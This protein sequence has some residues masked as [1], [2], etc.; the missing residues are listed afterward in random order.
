MTDVIL[1]QT[2]KER[3]LP[4]AKREQGTIVDGADIAS[5]F[6]SIKKQYPYSYV[7]IIRSGSGRL[8]RSVALSDNDAIRDACR[9]L[10]KRGAIRVDRTTLYYGEP[11]FVLGSDERKRSIRRHRRDLV[12]EY[13]TLRSRIRSLQVAEERVA[14]AR[15]AIAVEEAAIRDLGTRPP[16]TD[17]RSL[18]DRI[19]DHPAVL[20]VYNG[21]AGIPGIKSPICANEIAVLF[22][23]IIF[24]ED[25]A[26][27][28]TTPHWFVLMPKKPYL[29]LLRTY[30]EAYVSSHPHA[31]IR[32]SLC[33]GNAED[34]LA[35]VAQSGDAASLFWL[36]SAYR[37]GWNP[38]SEL[39]YIWAKSGWGL[40]NTC[41]LGANPWE[42][43]WDGEIYQNAVTGEVDSWSKWIP[44]TFANG[45]N[46]S[47]ID[48]IVEYNRV[49]PANALELQK[50][51][52]DD[53]YLP[54]SVP[55]DTCVLC[56]SGISFCPCHSVICVAC[57][58]RPNLCN[59][60]IPP[61]QLDLITTDGQKEEGWFRIKDDLIV[62][63][64]CDVCGE[65]GS[66][67]RLTYGTSESIRCD[68]HWKEVTD[69]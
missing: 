29:K 65:P 16:T 56:G 38:I 5:V 8:Q 14:E 46:R 63:M 40:W 42:E 37:L 61:S 27:A 53:Y 32:G 25:G 2:P 26:Y 58:L 66:W 45:D 68:K 3:T 59:C 69:A 19:A 64:L 22:L 52:R 49:V 31:N 20:A 1:D 43:W 34:S 60:E 12:H 18:I 36:A 35:S 54:P 28:P 23:P 39:S 41:R 15:D 13:D 9:F 57:N 67:L 44:A 48:H 10:S 21:P 30:S 55:P 50:M 11:T 6:K 7:A 51:L 17:R 4:P 24:Q 47:Y 62:L 33:M